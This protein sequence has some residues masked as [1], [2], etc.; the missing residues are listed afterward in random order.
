MPHLTIEYSAN[1]ERA[2]DIDSLVARVHAAAL[3][4]GTAPLD[5]LRTRAVRRDH[6]AIADRHPDNAFVAVAARLG[7]GRPLDERRR[8]VEA[9]LAAVVEGCG[10]AA[11]T[12][13]FSVEC[14]E[15]DPDTRVNDN[16]LRPLVVAR[17]ARS[18][19]PPAG[20]D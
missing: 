4:T 20:A 6:Y 3:S 15:I 13:M 19:T 7:P 17:A 16:R 11:D 12:T 8:F 9:L 5:A 18:D 1:L 10:D 14:T 2:V